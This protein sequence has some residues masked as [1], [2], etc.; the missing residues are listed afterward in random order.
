[1]SRSP[2]DEGGAANRGRGMAWGGRGITGGLAGGRGGAGWRGRGGGSEGGV[3][4][5][6]GPMRSFVLSGLEE[7]RK[8]S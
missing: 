6:A 1:M 5:T 8:A 7:E 3:A 2:L 4:G